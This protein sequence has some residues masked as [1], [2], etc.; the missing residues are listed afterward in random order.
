MFVDPKEITAKIY[1]GQIYGLDYNV[2]LSEI[3]MTVS[4]MEDKAIS[5]Y[6]L[7]FEGVRYFLHE[8]EIARSSYY[9]GGTHTLGLFEP[10]IVIRDGLKLFECSDKYNMEIICNEI[11][12]FSYGEEEFDGAEWN[13]RVKEGH[14]FR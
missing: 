11:K 9:E 12:L 8:Q 1:G 2:F 5:I 10:T 14:L 3:N 7:Q 4:V 13:R 6:K